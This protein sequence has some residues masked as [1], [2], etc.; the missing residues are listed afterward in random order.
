M[1][2]SDDLTITSIFAEISLELPQFAESLD[3]KLIDWSP[4]ATLHVELRSNAQRPR[5][6]EKD[7]AMSW[8]V[9]HYR[10]CDPRGT[11]PRIFPRNRRNHRRKY[12]CGSNSPLGCE[13]YC[14]S[15]AVC[16][17]PLEQK[18]HMHIFSTSQCSTTQDPFP[19]RKKARQCAL[20]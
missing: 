3:Q 11:S 6:P 19:A 20:L 5:N 2:K 16:D 9:L 18:S 12:V 13:A 4:L 8:N 15:V 1:R 7:R 14:P 10:A 17:A